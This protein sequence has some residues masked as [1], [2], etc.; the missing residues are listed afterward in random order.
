MVQDDPQ[1]A[2][3]NPLARLGISESDLRAE[4]LEAF[5]SRECVVLP[6]SA[7][8]FDGCGVYAIYYYG[9]DPRYAP[10]S[11]DRHD[12]TVPIYV[13]KA[14]PSGTRKGAAHF[15]PA[16]ESKLAQRLAEHRRSIEATDNLTVSQFR[17]RA[18]PLGSV[19]I[20]YA[21]QLLIGAYAPWWNCYIEGFGLHDVGS[22][23]AGSEMSVWDALHPG[24]SWVKERNLTLPTDCG[25]VWDECVAPAIQQAKQ[26]RT[27]K[28]RSNLDDRALMSDHAPSVEET[29]LFDFSDER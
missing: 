21:E 19:W 6:S 12:T 11:N 9:D 5:A 17:C 26:K 3:F 23:R 2:A 14:V 10:I 25:C 20:R 8:S 24:R 15:T 1:P 22:G 18:L 7:S 13:G 16:D 27:Y 28:D 4:I 29:S